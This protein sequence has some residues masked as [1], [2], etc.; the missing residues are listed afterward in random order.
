[1]ELN[2]VN[3]VPI[4][5]MKLPEDLGKGPQGP[6]VAVASAVSI[7]VSGRTVGSCGTTRIGSGSTDGDGLGHFVCQ[8]AKR[9]PPA[10]AD[11][12]PSAL[13]PLL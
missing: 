11:G 1:M 12:I 3:L 6:L 7:Y 10:A 4:L 9:V 8:D 13:Y 2:V 5:L